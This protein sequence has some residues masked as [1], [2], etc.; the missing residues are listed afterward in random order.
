VLYINW[1]LL[2]PYLAPGI[3]NPF[4]GFFL[5]SSRLPWSTDEHPL[6]AKSYQ[7]IL[8]LGYN[9]VFFSL[10]RQ[11]VAVKLSRPIAKYFG[12]KRETKLDRFGEQGYALVYFMVFGAWGFV[13][14]PPMHVFPLSDSS[15]TENYGAAAYMVV[16]NRILLDW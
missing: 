5:I 8:F 14:I 4:G 7:D 12:L 6:Y 1:E 11:V 10:V 16:S 15:S 3:P 2:S 13:R 9:V